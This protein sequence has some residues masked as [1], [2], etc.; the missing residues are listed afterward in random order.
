M[1]QR[2]S[3]VRKLLGAGCVVAVIL[4]GGCTSASDGPSPAP[5]PAVSKA[6]T[7]AGE[8]REPATT[9][10]P[11]PTPGSVG[12]TLAPRHVPRR[13]P[14]TLTQSGTAADGVLVSLPS[15]KAIT[16]KGVGPG[17]VSGPALRV[18]VRLRNTTQA[19]VD[20][21][22]AVV[23]LT[24]EGDRP[25]A[26]MNGAPATRLPAQLAAGGEVSAVYVF[27]VAP[28]RRNPVTIEV[29]VAGSMPTVVFRGRAG[30]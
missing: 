25:G 3:G 21:G 2:D 27:A 15:V 12:S 8:T 23:A 11:P 14:V 9:P 20:L 30:G 13:K 10:V 7:P 5:T 26:A 4:V 22:G 17:E 6:V 19:G 1:T 28:N 16:A 24:D 18:D 29:F